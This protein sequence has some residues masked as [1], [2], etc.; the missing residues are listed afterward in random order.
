MKMQ[1]V[2]LK[3]FVN[4]FREWLVS[5]LPGGYLYLSDLLSTPSILKMLSVIA[6]ALWQ[7]IDASYDWPA[8]KASS[9]ANAVADVLEHSAC[10]CSPWLKIAI[11]EW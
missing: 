3:I 7:K 10:Y 9:L 11:T 1:E 8:T 6:S 2:W 5:S 4:V